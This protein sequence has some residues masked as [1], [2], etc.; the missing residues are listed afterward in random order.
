MNIKS[1]LSVEAEACIKLT[2]EN[3]KL[4]SARSLTLDFSLCGKLL[5]EIKQQGTKESRA[6]PGITGFQTED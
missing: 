4:S 5:T 3:N 2:K 1:L 6:T